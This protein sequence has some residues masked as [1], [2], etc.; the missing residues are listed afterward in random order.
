MM[1]VQRG[2][3]RGGGGFTPVEDGVNFSAPA[4]RAKANER[5]NTERARAVG[6]RKG[7]RN[8]CFRKII[9]NFWAREGTRKEGVGKEHWSASKNGVQNSAK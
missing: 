9:P 2:R 1:M 7:S 8:L 4:E 3:R 6:G 5:R